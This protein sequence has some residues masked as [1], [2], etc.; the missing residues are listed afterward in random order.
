MEI[1]VV[2][3]LRCS[4]PV[5]NERSK[6]QQT[7][8]AWASYLCQCRENV[9]LALAAAKS[10]PGA[11]HRG[12]SSGQIIRTAR[13]GKARVL[14]SPVSFLKSP[15]KYTCINTSTADQLPC[16]LMGRWWISSEFAQHESNGTQ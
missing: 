8:A 16:E 2:E 9:A 7:F 12:R 3:D 13:H 10:R 6:V 5:I 4:T 11:L 14:R 15:V 1:E